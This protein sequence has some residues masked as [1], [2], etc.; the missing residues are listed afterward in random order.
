MQTSIRQSSDFRGRL[1]LDHR[2]L[3]GCHSEREP[4]FQQGATHLA[5]PH[6]QY[7]PLQLVP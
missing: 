6:E 7:V 3:V 2:E 5:A 4:A 1:W